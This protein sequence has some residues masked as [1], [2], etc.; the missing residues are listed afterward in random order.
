[1]VTSS[2]QDYEGLG[3]RTPCAASSATCRRP[4]APTPAAAHVPAEPG[5]WTPV[6]PV[7][8]SAPMTPDTIRRKIWPVGVGKASRR[9]DYRD[10]TAGAQVCVQVDMPGGGKE[11]LPLVWPFRR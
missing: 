3:F 5:V 7:P 4:N 2:S 8:D 11:V 10:A 9:W 1:M 6:L